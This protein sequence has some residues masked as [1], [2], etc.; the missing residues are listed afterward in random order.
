MG[1][2]RELT[3]AYRAR[4]KEPSIPR[5]L[6]SAGEKAAVKAESNRRLRNKLREDTFSHYGKKCSVCGIDDSDVLTIDHTAQDGAKHRKELAE[7]KGAT[8]TSRGRYSGYK[9]YQWLRT[10]GYPQG[11]RTLCFNCNIKA[12][13]NKS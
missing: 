9:F 7:R 8:S 5:R 11:F 6:K 12:F 10:N 4:N 3:Q 2:Q 1:C 13:R